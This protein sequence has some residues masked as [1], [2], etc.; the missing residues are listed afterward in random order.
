MSLSSGEDAVGPTSKKPPRPTLLRF[1]SSIPLPSNIRYACMCLDSAS[2]LQRSCFRQRRCSC[3]LVARRSIFGLSLS[4]YS[5]ASW[6]TTDSSWRCSSGMNAVC[7]DSNRACC[8]LAVKDAVTL[9][10]HFGWYHVLT[11]LGLLSSAWCRLYTSSARMS[12]TKCRHLHP[13]S[14]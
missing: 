1:S 5:T 2:R 7:D 4:V 6:P 9:V 8:S 13:Q 11:H 10:C 14:R 12:P 3:Q